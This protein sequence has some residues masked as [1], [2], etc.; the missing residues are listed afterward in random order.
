MIIICSDRLETWG[1]DRLVMQK[2]LIHEIKGFSFS[3]LSNDAQQDKVVQMVISATN[4]FLSKILT[5]Q[6]TSR[7]C[8]IWVSW[9]Q[10]VE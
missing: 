6:N 4:C 2:D 9:L 3:N 8:Q 7:S 5:Q 10:R 1:G